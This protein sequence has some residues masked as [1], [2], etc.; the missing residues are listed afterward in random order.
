MTN[1]IHQYFLIGIFM[2]LFICYQIFRLYLKDLG[3]LEELFEAGL[4]AIARI[5][6]DNTEAL[7]ELFGK[8][9][10]FNSLC[11]KDFLYSVYIYCVI[12]SQ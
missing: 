12:Y 8:P 11:F 4:A 10:L 2:L 1:A 7:A 5:G 6:I 3:D 9:S